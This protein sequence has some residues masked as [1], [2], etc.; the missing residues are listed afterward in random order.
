MSINRMI[1][2]GDSQTYGYG[3]RRAQCWTTLASEMTGWTLVN[4]GVSG[5]TTGGMMVRL[6]EILRTPDE[7]RED[8]CF[9]LMGGGNDIFFSG[10]RGGAQAN[11]AAMIQ[12]L[13]SAGE[14]PLV[15]IG[16]GIAKGNYPAA[17]AALV[18]FAEAEKK[19]RDYYAWLEQFCDAFGVRA[20]DFRADFCDRNGEVRP[21]FY[22]DGLHL[23]PEG[24]RV[25]AERIAKVIAVMD[26]E[27]MN[28]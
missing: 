26:R 1:C 2:L 10:D 13:F 8:R 22:L 7:K 9:L 11:I 24:Q 6:R 5:D 3:V 21:E 19:I 12:Q 17:W 25:M 14:M 18:N 16:P 23:N 28:P 15:A 4:H 27:R 20:V